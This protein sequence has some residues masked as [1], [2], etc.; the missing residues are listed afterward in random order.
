[1]RD[2][3]LPF[4]TLQGTEQLAHGK[5]HSE[6]LTATEH[7]NMFVKAIA[8][9]VW[10]WM[11]KFELNDATSWFSLTCS[12]SL[13]CQLEL[14]H[15]IGSARFVR[16]KPFPRFWPR[17]SRGHNVGVRATPE[18]L[19][20]R[21]GITSIRGLGFSVLFGHISWN[22]ISGQCMHMDNA[23]DSFMLHFH[24]RCDFLDLINMCTESL[25]ARGTWS[26]TWVNA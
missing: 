4:L 16:D 6:G 24:L 9:E 8:L 13:L 15:P 5:G 22:G 14:K 23:T 11:L 18:E 12:Q 21:P 19:S 3:A 7:R 17:I 25:L 20:K 26:G 2:K 1:M 10:V